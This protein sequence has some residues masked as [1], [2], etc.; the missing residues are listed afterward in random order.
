[1]DNAGI[2][3]LLQPKHQN[4]ACFPGDVTPLIAHAYSTIGI[5]MLQMR[6]W[7]ADR[8]SPKKIIEDFF[9]II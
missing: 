7:T 2:Y 8:W 6:R 5:L 1:M 9:H 4:K 3:G